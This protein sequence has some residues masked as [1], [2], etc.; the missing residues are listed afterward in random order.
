MAHGRDNN[1]KAYAAFVRDWGSHYVAEESFGGYCNFT[2]TFD[3][4]FIK[5]LGE[6]MVLEYSLVQLSG[7][8]GRLGL[9]SADF[10]KEVLNTTVPADFNA[11]VT[12]DFH[13]T[14][15]DPSLLGTPQAPVNNSAAAWSASVLTNPQRINRPSATR[16]NLLATLLYKAGP[17]KRQAMKDAITEYLNGTASGPTPSTAT[18]GDSL[19]IKNNAA[20]AEAAALAPSSPSTQQLPPAAPAAEK[21]ARGSDS[22]RAGS[23]DSTTCPVRHWL[24]GICNGLGTPGLG[25]G[26]DA[27]KQDGYGTNVN[28]LGQVAEM[29]P[30]PDRC[31][32]DPPPQVSDD[33]WVGGCAGGC[34]GARVADGR[35]DGGMEATH[36]RI[37]GLTN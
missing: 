16:Y 20:G 10:L 9:D 36:Y 1:Y 17:S 5:T 37:G 23:G 19:P 4:S 34:E 32:V 21:A 24:G 26:F 35:T 29:P 25:C 6:S 12:V 11:S 22:T 28:P 27:T 3:A 31:Y 15:G 14:G 30:C 7:L 8:L 13:C 18:H 33:G 2:V